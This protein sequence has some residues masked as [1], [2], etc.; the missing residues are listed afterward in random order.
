MRPPAAPIFRDAVEL[1]L[2]RRR[3][4]ARQGKLS[5]GE[6]KVFDA[7]HNRR[8]EIVPVEELMAT[9]GFTKASVRGCLHRLRARLGLD[10]PIRIETVW[11]RGYRLRER[12]A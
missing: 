6:Q 10:G 3:A 11:T 2:L 9:T 4:I 7:L 5:R 8:G 12:K 1:P